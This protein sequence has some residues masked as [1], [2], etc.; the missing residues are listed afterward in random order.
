MTDTAGLLGSELP[1]VVR[2]TTVT[3]YVVPSVSP[4]ITQVVAP[5][6]EQVKVPDA[7]VAVAVY[8]VSVPVP[9]LAG[10]V[11][12]IVAVVSPG[13]AVTPV[14][15]PGTIPCTTTGTLLA[16]VELFPRSPLALSPQQ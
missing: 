9:K 4:V 11:H 16:V 8:P 6:V 5:E 14:G 3:R 1:S 15:A 2:V 7:A 12:E 13:V 10:A